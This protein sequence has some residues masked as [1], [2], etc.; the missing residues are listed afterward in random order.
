L[1]I[2]FSLVFELRQ[3]VEDLQF[4]L[5]AMDEKVAILL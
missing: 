5:L 1:A 3:G 4:L 2:L